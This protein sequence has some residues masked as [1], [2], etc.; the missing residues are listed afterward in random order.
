MSDTTL[1]KKSDREIVIT[2]TFRAPP[3]IVFEVYTNAEH[4]KKWWAPKSRGAEI[5]SCTAE[6]RVGGAY[7]YVIRAAQAGE[8]AFSGRYVEI[9]SPSR[10][11]YTQVFEP[12]ADAGEAVITT[13]FD[14]R[15]GKTF[16]TSNE[17]YPSAEALEAALASG[18]EDGMRETLDQLDA[19]VATMR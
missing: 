7:R 17:L 4:V 5:V 9:T 13:L 11:V 18:M 3:R 10:L 15:D 12:M 14:E 1:T 6:V 8:F 16:M 2:R 19:L